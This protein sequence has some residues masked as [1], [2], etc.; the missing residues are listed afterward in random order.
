M[1]QIRFVIIVL[2]ILIASSSSSFS[3]PITNIPFKNSDAFVTI[4]EEQYSSNSKINDAKDDAKLVALYK[5]VRV[6]E[7]QNYHDIL[8]AEVN[9]VN[10]NKILF[11]MELAGDA[12]TNENYETVYLW[13]IYIS[14]TN[15]NAA[16]ASTVDKEFQLYTLIIP[17]FGANSNFGNNKTGWYLAVFNNT[18]NVY[19]LPLSKISNMPTNKVQVFIDP[20][21]IGN[22]SHF[23]YLV[24]SMIRVND[25]F[26]DK[27][28]DYFVDFAPDHFISFWKQWFR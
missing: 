9:K 24:S 26:L 25:T 10:D 8:S 3:L 23:N 19:T 12:N 13:L 18:N 16:D 27:P 21:F 7:I 20:I 17:N 28:P 6:P 22:P 5:T 11:T 14:I 2:T 4:F 15:D 1:Q